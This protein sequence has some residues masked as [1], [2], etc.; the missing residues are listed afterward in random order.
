MT[1]TNSQTAFFNELAEEF[2]R[3]PDLETSLP[4]PI[5]PDAAEQTFAPKI[6]EEFAEIDSYP[7]ETRRSLQ[8]VNQAPF[9]SARQAPYF[10]D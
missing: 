6:R 3:E 1:L 4:V 5:P 2:H 8:P 7:L 9:L 10:M